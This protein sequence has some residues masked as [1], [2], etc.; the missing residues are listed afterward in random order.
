MARQKDAQA[1]VRAEGLSPVREIREVFAQ[2]SVRLY[3]VLYGEPQDCPSGCFYLGGTVLKVG[4]RIGWIEFD[5][6]APKFDPV[7]SLYVPAMWG[8]HNFRVVDADTVLISERLLADLR[9]ADV[10]YYVVLRTYLGLYEDTPEPVL[11]LV[12]TRALAEVNSAAMWF[13]VTHPNS[14][15]SR[16][17][18]EYLAEFRSASALYREIRVRA[19][20]SLETFSERCAA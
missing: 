5:S 2:D 4:S 19:R 10:R 20:A 7:R 17:I 11:W 3:R 18:L 6:W 13:L 8:D 12:A 1:L 16:R 15:C 14:Q 9:A